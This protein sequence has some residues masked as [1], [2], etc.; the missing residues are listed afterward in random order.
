MRYEGRVASRIWPDGNGI[1]IWLPGIG[2]EI[3]AAN[4]Q[5]FAVAK[6]T[7]KRAT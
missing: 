2:A 4:V 5:Q 3:S 7:L 6:Q 1:W